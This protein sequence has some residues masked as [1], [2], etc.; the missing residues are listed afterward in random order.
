MLSASKWGGFSL[1]SFRITV[2]VTTLIGD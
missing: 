2:F 1:I